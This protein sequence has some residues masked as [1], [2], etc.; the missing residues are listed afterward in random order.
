MWLENGPVVLKGG[1]KLNGRSIGIVGSSDWEGSSPAA[2]GVR[3]M[4][5]V[6]KS[7]VYLYLYPRFYAAPK[8]GGIRDL[9]FIGSRRISDL[10]QHTI[11]GE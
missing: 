11:S 3:R 7:G 5:T 9:S 4:A 8:Y 2:L 1:E 6:C 10:G